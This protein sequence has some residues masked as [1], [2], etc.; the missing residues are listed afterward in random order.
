MRSQL[1]ECEAFGDDL[2]SIVRRGVGN[3]L[4]TYGMNFIDVVVA[5]LGAVYLAALI[6][7]GQYR[8]DQW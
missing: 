4:H 8:I 2:I 3:E 1:L 5:E 7:D 6:E